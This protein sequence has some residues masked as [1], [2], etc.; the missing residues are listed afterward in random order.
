MDRSQ[1]KVLG[2]VCLVVCAVSLF[3]AIERYN[4]NANNVR[5]MNAF[6]SSSPIGDLMGG[7]VSLKAATPAAAKYGIFFAALSGIGGAVL[8]AKS[9]NP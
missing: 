4:T 1:M 5:A 9:K 2:I 3:V 6:Q 7:A 8:L